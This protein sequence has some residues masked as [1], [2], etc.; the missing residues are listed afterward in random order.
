MLYVP[1]VFTGK[2]LARLAVTRRS[3]ADELP[4]FTWPLN[5]AVPAHVSAEIERSFVPSEIP[6]S[7]SEK[8]CCTWLASAV[9]PFVIV[10]V[11]LG[12]AMLL[13]LPSLEIDDFG[14]VRTRR[15]ELRRDLV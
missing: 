10:Y 11:R 2:S 5:V 8:F 4:R 13:S 1:V 6:F 3:S 14:N 12:A 15:V 9:V 7:K